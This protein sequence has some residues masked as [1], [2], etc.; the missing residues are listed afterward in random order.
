MG[1]LCFGVGTVARQA[2]LWG[3]RGRGLHS[4]TQLS[5]LA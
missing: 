1:K 5:G 4:H 3:Q 2:K